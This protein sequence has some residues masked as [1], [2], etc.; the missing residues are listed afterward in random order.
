MFYNKQNMS[1]FIDDVNLVVEY[2]LSVYMVRV[3]HLR[4]KAIL[5]AMEIV[6]QNVPD[7]GE[8]NEKLIKIANEENNFKRRPCFC[9]VSLF[10]FTVIAGL[11]GWICQCLFSKDAYIEELNEYNQT[12]IRYVE[13]LPYP[14]YIPFEFRS[15]T[16]KHIILGILFMSPLFFHGGI[17]AA[18]NGFFISLTC[19][20]C[21]HFKMLKYILSTTTVRCTNK[22]LK[23]NISHYD[24]DQEMEKEIRAC[25]IYLDKILK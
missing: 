5:Q 15:S 3:W 19:F 20:A 4:K 18:S 6:D 1:A 10:T 9:A 22:G 25:A 7:I 13:T 12:V 17:G 8:E 21:A 16:L 23:M 11:L 24:K 2:C 14:V